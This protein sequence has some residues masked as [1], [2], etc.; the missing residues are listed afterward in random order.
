MENQK[1]LIGGI[2][3]GGA[4]GIAAGLLLAPTAGKKMRSTLM[5]KSGDLKDSLV[6]TVT[7]SLDSIKNHFN[8]KIDELASKSKEAVDTATD[9]LSSKART[10]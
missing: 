9:K 3:I 6:D 7:D 5:K 4:I 2:L 1:N 8:S 10:V